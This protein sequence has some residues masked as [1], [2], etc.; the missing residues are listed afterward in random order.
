M[1]YKFIF[2]DELREEKE[3]FRAICDDMDI[4]FAE[5]SGF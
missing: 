5:M 4:T 3:K 2:S 1:K